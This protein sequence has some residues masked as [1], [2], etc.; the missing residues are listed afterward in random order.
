M[1]SAL[2]RLSLSARNMASISEDETSNCF[3]LSRCLKR[4][5]NPSP[6]TINPGKSLRKLQQIGRR[7]RVCA[8]RRS[9]QRPYLSRSDFASNPRVRRNSAG[10]P[11]DPRCWPPSR[12]SKQ[13]LPASTTINLWAPS[14]REDSKPTPP[15]PALAA[16]AAAPPLFYKTDARRW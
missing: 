13:N 11:D 2:P 14:L 12:K 15:A 1:W 9:W 16:G 4:L 6:K 8:R 7:P 10:I 5:R 3:E